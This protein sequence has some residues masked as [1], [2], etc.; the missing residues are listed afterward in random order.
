MLKHYISIKSFVCRYIYAG[1]CRMKGESA[2]CL[3]YVAKKYD[4][5]TLIE[6][7]NKYLENNI[8]VDNVCTILNQT[9][10]FAEEE[11]KHKC[12]EFI[13]RDTEDVLQSPDFL[14]LSIDALNVFLSLDKMNITGEEQIYQALKTWAATSCKKKGLDDTSEENLRSELVDVLPLIRFP[15]MSIEVFTDVV[16]NDN[17]LKDAEKLKVVKDIV[18]QT[19][20]SIYSNVKRSQP[21]KSFDIERMKRTTEMWTHRGNQDGISFVVSKPAKLTDIALY[22]PCVEG[23]LSGPLEVLD[24]TTLL[25]S[26]NV[27]LTHTGCTKYNFVC[28][29]KPVTLKP[30]KI[31]SIRHR[32]VGVNTYYGDGDK[33]KQ[34]FGDL[35]IEFI[36]LQTGMSDN[37]TTKDRGQIHGIRICRI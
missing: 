10:V 8:D 33:G 16:I 3:L 34:E 37:S 4:L 7:C 12:L 32:F 27:T 13:A 30:D 19:S 17:I 9:V 11:L 21:Y 14:T 22:L 36:T 5:P 2:L 35:T 15:T 1:T 20:T 18:G 26:D 23:T 25:V 29:T 6:D 24:D 28:L 31:Y